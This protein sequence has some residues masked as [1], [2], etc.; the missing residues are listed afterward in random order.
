M[1]NRCCLHSSFGNLSSEKAWFPTVQDV[2]GLLVGF[3]VGTG[4]ISK[5][6]L[7]R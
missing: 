2:V 1:A 7:M 4:T 3:G 5:V 6:T